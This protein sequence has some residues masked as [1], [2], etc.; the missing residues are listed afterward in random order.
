MCVCEF[1]LSVF[2]S[3]YYVVCSAVFIRVLQTVCCNRTALWMGCGCGA[4]VRGGGKEK[5][6]KEKGKS[7]KNWSEITSAHSLKRVCAQ[8][9]GDEK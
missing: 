5:R 6:D 1:D 3:V 7:E 8:T 9:V 2:Y 4:N